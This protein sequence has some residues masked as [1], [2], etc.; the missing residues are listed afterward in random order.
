MNAHRFALFACLA[1]GFAVT[2][3]GQVTDT[4]LSVKQ[5]AADY[6]EEAVRQSVEGARAYCNLVPE[7][8]RLAFRAITDV[9]GKGPVLEVHCD[10]F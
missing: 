2:G 10:R 4:I 6:S 9:A 8:R 3:C 5:S 1:C 7:Q